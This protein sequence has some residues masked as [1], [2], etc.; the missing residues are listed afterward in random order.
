VF[1]GADLSTLFVTSSRFG[2]SARDL[3]ANVNDG[4]LFA[5]DGVSRGLPTTAFGA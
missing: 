2:M 1:G 3:A 5:V 4:G